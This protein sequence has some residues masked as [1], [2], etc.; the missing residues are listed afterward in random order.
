MRATTKSM[1]AIGGLA[2]LSVLAAPA[3]ARAGTATLYELTENMKILT[4]RHDGR[5]STSRAATSELAGVA[6]V[7]TP[8]CPS[9]D[10]ASGP[11]GCA[12]NVTGSDNVSLATGLGMLAGTFTTVVQGDNPV[13]GPEA[14]VLQGAFNGRMD[15]SPAILNQVPFGTVVGKVYASRHSTPFTGVFRLPFAGNVTTT[16]DLGS[17]PVT[18]T[19]RQI[20][21]P[22]TPDPNP[23]AAMY[24]GWDLA[25]LDN[26]EAAGTP[27]GRCL[28][29][30][31]NE[32]SLGTPLVR[33]DISF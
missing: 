15:F 26:V 8:L 13:D 12:V 21:C 25:Y 7:G 14:V 22:A 31:P 10:L 1:I 9:A 23:Y 28:D 19:L 17:G 29:I 2:V 20:F 30:Q 5:T 33:F 6:Q 18:V 3:V 27:S 16:M 4:T 24:G 32:L 11:G